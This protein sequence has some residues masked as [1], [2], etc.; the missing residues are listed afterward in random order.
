MTEILNSEEAAEL[1]RVSVP[2][3]RGMASSGEIPATKIGDD[4]R[5]V[6][7]QL[8]NYMSTRAIAEQRSRQEQWAIKKAAQEVNPATPLKRGRPSKVKVDLATYQ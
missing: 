3:I 2:T 6:K 8:L 5:F 7:S 4:W 1:M